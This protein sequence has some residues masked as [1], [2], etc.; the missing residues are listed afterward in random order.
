[1]IYQGLFKETTGLNSSNILGLM[2]V[3]LQMELLQ[4]GNRREKMVCFEFCRIIFNWDGLDLALK[5]C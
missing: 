1:M 5:L 3:Y 4:K 2:E